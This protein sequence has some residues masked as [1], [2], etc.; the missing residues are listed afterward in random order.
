MSQQITIDR[1]ETKYSPK[2]QPLFELGFDHLH[3]NDPCL[4]YS[5]YGF[6]TEDMEE[7]ISLALDDSDQDFDYDEYREEI[8]RFYYATLHAVAILGQMQTVDA[9]EPILHRSYKDESNDYLFEIIPRFLTDVGYD[10]IAIIEKHLKQ[11][12]GDRLSLFDGITRIGKKYPNTIDE[13]SEML[14]DYIQFSNDDS[15]HLSFA[16]S[17][18][19]DLTADKH[20][21]FIRDMFENRDIDILT[22]GDIED[23]EIELGLRKERSSPREKNLWQQAFENEMSQANTTPQR[24]EVKIGRNDPCPCGSGKKYKK[25]CLNK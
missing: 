22:R 20:I 17:S 12:T 23:I 11:E 21:D 5:R 16:L 4:D 9:I 19:I 3:H 25:C 18:L 10:A 13:L 24:A 7:L 15:T 1:L 14:I 8:D 6:E 2:I